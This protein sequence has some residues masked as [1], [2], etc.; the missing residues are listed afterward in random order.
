[1]TDELTL[2]SPTVECLLTDTLAL[3]DWCLTTLDRHL[4]VT[5][6]TVLGDGCLAHW[7]GAWVTQAEKVKAGERTSIQVTW[8]STKVT[9]VTTGVQVTG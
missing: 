1:M 3:D 2:V 8:E 6:A 9:Q 7:T 4:E 5:T